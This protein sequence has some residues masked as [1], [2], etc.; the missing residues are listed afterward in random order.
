MMF[1]EKT[2]P[3]DW[4]SWPKQAGDWVKY[5]SLLSA[6]AVKEYIRLKNNHD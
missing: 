5:S 1:I 4:E 3:N 2:F 6:Q